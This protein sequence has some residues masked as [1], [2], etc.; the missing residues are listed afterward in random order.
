[1]HPIIVEDVVQ[2]QHNGEEKV[3][4]E[5]SKNK[6]TRQQSI[7]IKERVLKIN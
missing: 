7:Q 4:R 6:I 3:Q 5:E 1:M 2:L